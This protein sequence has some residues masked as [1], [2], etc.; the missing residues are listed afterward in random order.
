MVPYRVAW[1]PAI[2]WC[3]L[4]VNFS[5]WHIHS[6]SWHCLAESLPLMALPCMGI[7]KHMDNYGPF[8]V[9]YDNQWYWHFNDFNWHS[10]KSWDS[11]LAWGDPTPGVRHKLGLIQP[12]VIGLMMK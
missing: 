10:H 12:V 6:V 3:L 8:M 1:I 7:G 9:D 11:I 2:A 5:A 4:A